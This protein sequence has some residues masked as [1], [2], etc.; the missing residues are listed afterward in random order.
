MS[1]SRDLWRIIEKVKK[2]KMDI[3]NIESGLNQLFEQ[4]VQEIDE[5]EK[6]KIKKLLKL[7]WSDEDISRG[8]KIPQSKIIS[9]MK[10]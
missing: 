10:E 3:A 9:I 7:G 1:N 8:L 4:S 5:Q 2:M 6:G